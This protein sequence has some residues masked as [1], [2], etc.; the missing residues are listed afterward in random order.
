MVVPVES[1]LSSFSLFLSVSYLG[2]LFLSLSF[3]LGSGF[4]VFLVFDLNLRFGFG[5]FGAI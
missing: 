3:S 4:V 5:V 1:Y 2:L